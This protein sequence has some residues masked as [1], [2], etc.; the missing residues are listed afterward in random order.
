M[1]T[2]KPLVLI[3]GQLQQL[4]AADAFLPAVIGQDASNRFVTD[5]EKEAWNAKADLAG[6]TFTGEVNLPEST[7]AQASLSIPHG[8]A[9][10]S[11]VNGDVWTTTAGLYLRINGTTRTMA[12]T[13]TWSTVS[14]AE[15]EAGTATG[16]RLWSAL[17]VNQAVAALAPVKSVAGKTGTVTLDAADVGLAP[18]QI[19]K[20]TISTAQPTGGSDGDLWFVYAG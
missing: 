8:V 7:T 9:P 11:P 3:N 1:A 17:R 20:I 15:A 12:H 4:S 5:A 14:Q 10:S 13:A 18:D 6:A 19:R 16:Q 2:Q